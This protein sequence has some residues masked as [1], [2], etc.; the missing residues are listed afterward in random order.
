MPG[1]TH[2]CVQ[3]DVYTYAHM[4]RQICTRGKLTHVCNTYLFTCLLYMYVDTV[5]HMSTT[6][7][8][9]DIH[10]C[11]STC[12]VHTCPCT[13]AYICACTHIHISVYII[14]INLHIFEAAHQSLALLTA[15]SDAHPDINGGASAIERIPARIRRSSA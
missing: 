12:N 4:H 15:V 8:Y 11:K 13:L 14:Y 3:T 5:I 6:C 9:T 2:L 1:Y 10:T 7:P